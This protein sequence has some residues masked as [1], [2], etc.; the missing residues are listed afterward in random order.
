MNILKNDLNNKFFVVRVLSQLKTKKKKTEE[1]WGFSPSFWLWG[2][3]ESNM[4]H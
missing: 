2:N 3:E 1:S 4:P